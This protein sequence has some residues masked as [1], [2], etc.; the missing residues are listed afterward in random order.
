MKLSFRRQGWWMYII[1]F[2]ISQLSAAIFAFV[3]THVVAGIPPSTLMA[4]ALLAANTL[5]ILLFF[6]CRPQSVT[7]QHTLAGLKGRNGRRTGL[8]LLLALPMILLTHLMQEIFFPDIPD[9]VGEETFKTIIFHPLGLLTVS[10][11][12]PL[13]EELLFRGGV[14]TDLTLNHS[15][16]GWAVPILLS[17][18]IF[19]LIH[20]N[21]AQMP[22]AFILGCL[23]GY[24]YWW[25]GSLIAPVCIH[26]F[27]N[28][29]ASLLMNLFP[30]DDSLVAFLGGPT[31][32]GITALVCCFFLFVMIRII[33]HQHQE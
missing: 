20:M 1:L 18:A 22:A 2:I 25:T 16:Q 24:A 17:A 27:N 5:A 31:S 21:P 33:Q 4:M 14:Q 15:D 9:L 10:L 13:A 8:V 3:L 29:L 7:L 32:A 19:T 26:V 23:L 11:L 28:S 12:G 30:D 6:C